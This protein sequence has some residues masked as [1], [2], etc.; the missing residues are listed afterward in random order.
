MNESD[1]L[2]L[3]CTADGNPKPVVLWRRLSSE[4]VI[5][6]GPVYN[7]FKASRADTGTY[8]CTAINSLDTNGASVSIIVMVQCKLML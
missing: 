3:Q 7:I 8:T 6:K 4:D 5:T 1:P 2:R